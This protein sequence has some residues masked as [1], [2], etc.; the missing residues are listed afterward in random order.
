MF[1][2]LTPFAVV[3]GMALVA[4]YALLGCTWLIWRSEG[5]LQ[6]WAYHL[7]KTLLIVVLGFIL[8]VSIWTPLIHDSDRRSAGSPGPTSCSC[9]PS[10]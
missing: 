5:A 2:W 1:D 3:C 10:R 6:D 4:G 8:L 9:R 7:A